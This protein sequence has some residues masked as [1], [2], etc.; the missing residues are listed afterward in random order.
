M[1]KKQNFE[2]LSNMAAQNKNIRMS[3]ILVSA[4]KKGENGHIT[5]GIEGNSV[6]EIA[7]D[8][9][10][11]IPILFLV[12]KKEYFELAE[13]ESELEQIWEKASKY[14]AI[15]TNFLPSKNEIIKQICYKAGRNGIPENHK[16]DCPGTCRESV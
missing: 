1:A 8:P 2:I 6:T 10:K 3:T 11:Y 15:N 14:D 12:D 7:L 16:C 9:D 4:N 13:Q 5:M